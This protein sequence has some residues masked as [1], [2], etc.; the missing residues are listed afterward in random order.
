ME[1]KVFICIVNSSKNSNICEWLLTINEKY[2]N[3]IDRN[4]SLATID[5]LHDW[6]A[7]TGEVFSGILTIKEGRC[8]WTETEYINH[9]GDIDI[10][11]G[12]ELL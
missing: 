11:C 12:Y 10:K 9:L 4:Y 7:A 5:D 1:V 6:V 8:E 3:Q 2:A